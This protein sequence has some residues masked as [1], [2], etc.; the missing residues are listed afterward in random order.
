MTDTNT[1]TEAYPDFRSVPSELTL[2]DTWNSRAVSDLIRSQSKDGATPA[3][4]FV[5]IKEA[6]LLKRHL[7]AS[8]GDDAVTTLVGTYYMGLEIVPIIAES[9]IATG[10][11][12]SIRTLQ[13]PVS[14]RPEWR[15]SKVETLWQF[16]V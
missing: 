4:L 16:R 12:K 13:D 11:C 2:G 7:A 1:N 9:F 6:D 5:G 10:G 14:R 3:F 8:F 15:D